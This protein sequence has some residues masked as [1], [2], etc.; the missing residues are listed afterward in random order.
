MFIH[1][2]F[3]GSPSARRANVASPL[4]TR[5]WGFASGALSRFL[6]R[7]FS[8]AGYPIVVI[9]QPYSTA[10]IK[11]TAYQARTFSPRYLEG[12][13]RRLQAPTLRPQTM[14]PLL[15][16]SA[17][18]FVLIILGGSSS[19]PIAGASPSFSTKQIDS[20]MQVV[21]AKLEQPQ[22]Q[23]AQLGTFGQ[24][25]LSCYSILLGEVNRSG[26]HG[27][28]TWF[29]CSGIHKAV[30]ASTTPANFSCTGFSS[31]VWIEPVGKTVSYTAMTS[32]SQYLTL[33]SSAPWEIQN[34]LSSAYNLVHKQSYQPVVE[35]ALRAVHPESQPVCF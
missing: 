14:N 32:A 10:R 28:Y 26:N 5:W 25:K 6:P 23:P 21:T 35:R 19:S 30:S 17:V 12:P 16:I 29:T 27:L 3:K 20:Y 33:R 11:T 13:D 18:A 15:K 1:K 34:K 8:L 24:A 31:A 22:S 2:T 9:R 4:I 7:N